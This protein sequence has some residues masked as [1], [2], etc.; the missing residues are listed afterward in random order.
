[1]DYLGRIIAFGFA[2]W[3]G[4]L[5]YQMLKG[6][7]QSYKNGLSMLDPEPYGSQSII[8]IISGVGMVVL[9][10]AFAF[11]IVSLPSH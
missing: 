5:L 8:V 10:L 4:W 7:W 11:G 1:M 2:L 6:M 3:L 9:L